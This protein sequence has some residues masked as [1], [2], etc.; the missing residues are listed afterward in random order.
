MSKE[1]SSVPMVPKEWPG[2]FGL[3]KHSKPA[4]MLNLGA[5]LLVWLF[6]FVVTAIFDRENVWQNTQ[7]SVLQIVGFLLNALASAALV[8][9]YLNSIGKKKIDFQEAFKQAWPFFVNMVLFTLLGTLIAIGSFLLFII[10]FFIVMPRLALA[11]YFLIDQK[12]GVVDSFKA[13]W[14]ATQGH[15][16]KVW[17]IFGVNLLMILLMITI[18]G[19]PVAIYLL[20]MYS[21][22][23]PILY[24]FLTHK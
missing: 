21:A 15:V 10:P 18:I 7:D 22:A 23:L 2:A 13:S 17:G 20:L 19:I 1:N 11:N 24:R 14:N 8:I 6:T 4:V 12:M 9:V 5:L 16:G 3:F